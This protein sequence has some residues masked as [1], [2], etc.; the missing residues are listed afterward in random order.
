[1]SRFSQNKKQD[2][3]Q[4]YTTNFYQRRRWYSNMLHVLS[5]AVLY[6]S[7]QANIIQKEYFY[8]SIPS[9]ELCSGVKLCYGNKWLKGKYKVWV[10]KNMIQKIHKKYLVRAP[11]AFIIFTYLLVYP[12]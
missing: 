11:F 5:I 1:M 6:V 7:F 12:V 9:W 8:D 10:K 4:E 3:K 2:K